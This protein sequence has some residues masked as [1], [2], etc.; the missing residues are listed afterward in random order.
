MTYASTSAAGFIIDATAIAQARSSIFLQTLIRT[1]LAQDRRIVIPATA[2]LQ[3]SATGRI[4]TRELHH[5]GITIVALTDAI[6]DDIAAI[7]L[8]ATTPVDQHIAHA[9]YESRETGFYPIVT[10][11]PSAYSSLPFP[12]DL[13]PLP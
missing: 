3:A 11:E 6:I 10:A 8:S 5:R 2:L 7:M 12:L 9:A 1:N 4:T 13:E